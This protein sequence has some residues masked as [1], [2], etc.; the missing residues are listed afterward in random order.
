M[1]TLTYFLVIFPMS[2]SISEY[3]TTSAYW[4]KES[5]LK[6]GNLALVKA[7]ITKQLISYNTYTSDTRTD[8]VKFYIIYIFIPNPTNENRVESR[9]CCTCKNAPYETTFWR[10]PKQRNVAGESQDRCWKIWT[11]PLEDIR[12][13][14]YGS[15]G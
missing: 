10:Q 14:N 15:N 4:A 2:V 7:A 1:T 9:T 8:L 12:L 5:D 3:K 6:I 11:W 13:S